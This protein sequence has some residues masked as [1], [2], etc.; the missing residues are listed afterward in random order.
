MGYSPWGHRKSDIVT[1]Q[2]QQHGHVE[3][4]RHVVSSP[5]YRRE[6]IAQGGPTYTQTHPTLS[7]VVR[8][9]SRFS[10]PR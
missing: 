3:S 2:Q 9:V 1:K 5:L 7:D 6:I 4:S 8:T 10:T